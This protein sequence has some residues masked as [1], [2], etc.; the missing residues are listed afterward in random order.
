MTLEVPYGRFDRALYRLAFANVDL[1]IA[2]NSVECRL[3]RDRL[4]QTQ[5]ERPV[6]VTSLPRA[7]TTL[8]LDVLN[9]L[10]EFAAATYRHMP[11]ALNPLLW[12]SL[13]AR[14]QR[15]SESTERLH[16]DGMEV[17]FDSPEAF[18][19][20]V[21]QAFWRDHYQAD[22]IQPWSAT[23]RRPA[24]ERFF[25]DYMTKIV[26]SGGRPANRYLSKNNANIAR[27]DLLSTLF[28]DATFVVPVRHPWAQ[29]ASLLRQHRHFCRIHSDDPFA[30]RYM[31]W[32]G[33]FEFGAGL[34]PIG[35]DT[36]HHERGVTPDQPAFWLACWAACYEAV[37]EAS[38][39][40]LV[41]IDYD[42]LCASPL[43]YLESLA[44]ALA[45]EQPAALIAKA[46]R[47]RAATVAPEPDVPAS[48]K[49]R[50]RDVHQALLAR[51]LTPGQ[52]MGIAAA[53]IR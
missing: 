40:R 14:F 3:F 28:P 10:P 8:L 47:F 15:R 37:L 39:E 29:A 34:R 44:D 1:Q 6:F 36:W 21:W 25:R 12:P 4:A 24:F 22:R 19:E 45:V 53:G 11:F 31:T 23:D 41:H 35:F 32:L 5:C 51:C 43:E 33:H 20:I 2:L 38:P 42:G 13:A 30:R 18:E 17:G 48:L 49:A 26:A 50:C 9:M 16:G 27:L 52:S 46:Y 7:G